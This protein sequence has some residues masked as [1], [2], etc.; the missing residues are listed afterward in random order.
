MTDIDIRA[1]VSK[2]TLADD[3]SVRIYGWAAMSRDDLGRPVVDSDGEH[4]PI[5]ELE[6]AAQRAFLRRGG[7]GSVGVMHQDF[8]RADLVESFVLS[9]EKREAFGL[10]QGPEGWMVGIESRDSEVADL[11]RKGKLLELS[12]RGRAEVITQS[13]TAIKSVTKDAFGDGRYGETGV[14][15]MRDLELADVELLSIVDRGASANDRVRSRIVL[16]KRNN[17][18]N[19]RGKTMTTKARSAQAIVTDLLESGALSE[20]PAEDKEA[21]MAAAAAVPM[22][23]PPV[24]QEVESSAQMEDDNKE[25]GVT[26]DSHSNDMA[27]RADEL[28]RKNAELQKRLTQLEKAAVKR[29]VEAFVKSELAY[30]PMATD[31]LVGLVLEA[32]ANLAKN[33]AESLET[34]LRS[35]S[36]I[37][38]KSELLKTEGFH[39]GDCA[40]SDEPGQQ[41][42]DLAKSIK[43]K[44]KA[45][46][47]SQAILE[48]GKQRPDLWRARQAASRA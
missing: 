40:P 17:T 28:S 29:D 37:L 24:E 8:A 1:T 35:T 41:L 39:R 30:V 45:L 42:R 22:A 15:V 19:N 47:M 38:A 21:L 23:T 9:A 48:A 36:A 44:N 14:G 43:E 4:I 12:I 32:R 16:V 26:N 13:R 33:D 27:K 3:G 6:K 7:R 11:V 31:K 2:S 10:G 18:R 25:D 34:M 20:L 46:S 5:N